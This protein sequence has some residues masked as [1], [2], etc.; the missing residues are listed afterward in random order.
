[1]HASQN[2]ARALLSSRKFWAL[3]ASIVTLIGAVQTG[4]MQ[5]A[6]AANTLVAALAAYSLATG[7]DDSGRA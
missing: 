7:I 6:E 1:M 3:A 5:P 4:T 2:K